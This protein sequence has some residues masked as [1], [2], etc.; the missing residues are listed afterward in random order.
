MTVFITEESQENLASL[1]RQFAASANRKFQFYKRRQPFLGL[2]DV[3]LSIAAMRVSNPDR[4]PL[5]SI[6]ATQPKLQP[7]LRRLS[8]M[9]SQCS[10]KCFRG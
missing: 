2:H 3:T 10:E 7:A 8:A 6:A 4:S 9:I 1:S 5:E